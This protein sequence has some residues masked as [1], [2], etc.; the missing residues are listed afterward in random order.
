[1]NIS[2]N[3]SIFA[4]HLNL[5]NMAINNSIIFDINLH[6]FL[7][8]QGLHFVDARLHNTAERVLLASIKEIGDKI[9]CSLE[10]K[11]GVKNEGGLQDYYEI[12]CN[13][14]QN[15]EWLKSTLCL[16][17]GYF[18]KSFF[19]PK[20]SKLDDISKR[21][22]I[23]LK[24]KS[25][26]FSEEEICCL[27]SGDRKLKALRSHFYK[28]VSEDHSIIEIEA[29]CKERNGIKLLAKSKI[30]RPDFEG[31]IIKQNEYSD[32]TTIAGATIYIVSPILVKGT[33]AK[34]K[35]VYSNEPIDFIIDDQDFLNQVY[36]KEIKFGNGTCIKCSLTILTKTVY[37][38]SEPDDP[39]VK[40]YY[41]VDHISQWT[42][43]EHFY[44]ETKKYR[45]LKSQGNYTGSLFDDFSDNDNQNT[46][47]VK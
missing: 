25:G 18:I 43:D 24:L 3:N 10:A 7:A 12:I 45:R 35:G 28:S 14:A 32:S 33:R 2:R 20:N 44:Y 38:D 13:I 9:G 5:C 41:S 22:D 40:S 8:D 19:R 21:I 11:V 34:W 27:I 36:N 31:H 15:S 23:A 4:Y 1:M 17:I 26:N 16:F 47:K 30:E 37:S 42:D 6:Y 39:M 46:G 29:C